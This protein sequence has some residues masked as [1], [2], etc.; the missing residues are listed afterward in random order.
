MISS[1]QEWALS[2]PWFLHWVG[3]LALGAIPFVESYLGSV[4]GVLSGLSPFVA[5][6]VAIGGNVVSMLAFVFGAHAVRGRVMA[7]REEAPLTPRKQ[8]LKERFDRY[9]V[10]G[11]S[12]LGQMVLPSQITSALIVSFGASR[13]R[14]I[15]WQVISIILWGVVCG[16]LAVYGVNLFA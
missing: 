2:L 10:A 6:P 15:L 5:I 1:V 14:V 16:I 4:I 7:G 11:V 3:I 9:G 13:N 8:K 12:L